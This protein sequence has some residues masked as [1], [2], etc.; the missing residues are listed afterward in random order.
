MLVHNYIPSTQ[1]QRQGIMT[2]KVS[3]SY[4]ERHCP[5]KQK[6]METKERK[7]GKG[8]EISELTGFCQLESARWSICIVLLVLKLTH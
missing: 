5:L 2:L 4:I 8:L 1:I 6:E 7:V 3:L